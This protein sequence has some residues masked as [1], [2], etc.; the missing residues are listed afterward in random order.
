[1]G[2]LSGRLVVFVA[3][4]VSIFGAC[5]GDMP[6]PICPDD[7]PSSCPIPA[8]GFAADAEP[9]I[10]DHCVKCHAPGGRAQRFPFQS[11][12][13]IGPFAGDIKL[14]L[15][16]CAM[17]LPPEPALSPSERQRLFG[18]ILCGALND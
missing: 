18:W 4:A 10:S 15:E 2:N 17:P 12:N 8:P 6:A 13:Q 9:I 7:A 1:V 16:L 11:Y 14:Q 5:G 3:A